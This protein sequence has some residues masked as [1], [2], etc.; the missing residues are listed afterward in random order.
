MRHPVI[1][2]SLLGLRNF[3]RE[4][5]RLLKGARSDEFRDFAN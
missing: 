2:H 1:A 3:V 4:P 5:A